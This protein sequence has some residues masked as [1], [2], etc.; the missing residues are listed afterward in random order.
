MIF[1]L[2]SAKEVKEHPHGSAFMVSGGDQY[3]KHRDKKVLIEEG[4]KTNV[5]V[6]RAVREIVN[7]IADIDI[8][9]SQ[10]GTVIDDEKTL[11]PSL[12]LLQKPNPMNGGKQFIKNIFVDYL[13]TGEMF[14]VKTPTGNQT[15]LEL[16]S[17]NPIDMEVKPGAKGIP[18][19]YQH[20]VNNKKKSFL[21]EPMTGKSDVFHFKAYNPLNYWRGM[22]PLEAAALAGDTHNAG[23]KWNYGLLKNGARPSGLIK[24][25]HS[26]SDETISRLR[27]YFKKAVQGESNAGQI[28][29]LED[30]ADWVSMDNSPRDMDYVNTMK[31]TAKYV[32]AAFGVPLPLIDNDSASYNNI[33]Q[34]KERLW[35]DTILP[36][37]NEFLEAFSNWLLP[38]YGDGLE[39]VADLDSIPALES[40]RQRK[41]ERTIAAVNSGVISPDEARIALGYAP[42][43]GV[44][45]EL[46]VSANMI[47][48]ELSSGTQDAPQMRSN[49]IT[50]HDI[51]YIK[52]DEDE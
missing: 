50:E 25:E 7:G 30:G 22:P 43:G 48:L 37:F 10:N 2:F 38:Y 27:E 51:L 26:P 1:N 40:L 47:P 49:G 9:I 14:I 16:W 15:P 34:A 46:L 42:R 19:E 13:I 45:D 44:A 52:S 8:D 23:M 3:I 28:P 31:E 4:Y 6:Y 39:F 36:L 20:N 41:F 17:L 21:V 24:F 12:E 5:I 35:T 33:E 11:H 18:S 32:A 29:M